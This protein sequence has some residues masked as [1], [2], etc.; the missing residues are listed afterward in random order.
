[1]KAK[2]GQTVWTKWDDSKVLIAGIVIKIYDGHRGKRY[3][4]QMENGSVE[5][6]DPIQVRRVR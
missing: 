2:V 5:A 4:V 1:M 6:V 3:R